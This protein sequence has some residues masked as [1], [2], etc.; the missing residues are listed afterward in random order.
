MSGRGYRRACLACGLMLAPEAHA[1]T[2]LLADI[3]SGE[4]RLQPLGG[5]GADR[6]GLFQVHLS[7][8]PDGCPQGRRPCS[9]GRAGRGHRRGPGADA[10]HLPARAMARTSPPSPSRRPTG[11]RTPTDWCP[12]RRSSSSTA[13]AS[14]G[15]RW[16][17]GTATAGTAWPWL[18][19][20]R[21]CRLPATGFRRLAPAEAVATA[22]D[23]VGPDRTGSQDS[24]GRARQPQASGRRR[25]AAL[26]V[27]ERSHQ[28]GPGE[29]RG[30]HDDDERHR[31][32]AVTVRRPEGGRPAPPGA[33]RPSG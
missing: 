18:P 23:P 28:V 25:F 27:V 29:A 5:R 14:C 11:S 31:A 15:T 17:A 3:D 30:D 9:L 21:R 20:G 8:V 2:F 4:T 22:T 16:S 19:V 32:T 33:P 26:R 1:P 24:S 6:A 7:R 13:T 12:C 10:G